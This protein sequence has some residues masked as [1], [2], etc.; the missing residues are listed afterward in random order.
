[1]TAR[2]LSGQVFSDYR[3]WIVPL[4]TIAAI[5]LGVYLL[6]VYPLSLKVAASERRAASVAEQLRL[7]KRDSD[8]VHTTLSRTE[9]ADRDLARFYHDALPADLSGARRLTYAHLAALAAAHNLTVE[10][11][12]YSLDDQYKGRLQRLVISMTLSG[13]YRDV[14]SFLYAVETAPEFVTIE[15]LGVAESTR[16]GGG[17]AVGIRLAT[18]FPSGAAHAL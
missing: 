14:R 2:G 8:A 4:A 18:Y 3:R 11:R 10:R 17:L 16:V 1:M 7:A 6:A 12:S 5:N 9:E 15:D 13:E